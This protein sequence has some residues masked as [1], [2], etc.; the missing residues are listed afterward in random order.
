VWMEDQGN[1]EDATTMLDRSYDMH[2]RSVLLLV[3][4]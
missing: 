3:E 1:F 2:E 4:K